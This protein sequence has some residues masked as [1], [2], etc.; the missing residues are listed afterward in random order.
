[1]DCHRF[2][3]NG[4]CNGMIGNANVH[5]WHD[6]DNDGRHRDCRFVETVELSNLICEGMASV[7]HASRV[8]GYTRNP[9]VAVKVSFVNATA[10]DIDNH[11][12]GS[13]RR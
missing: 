5:E 12:T 4:Q 7:D 8:L 11:Y 10:P 9:A 3:G 1:M 13:K 6:D 2:D